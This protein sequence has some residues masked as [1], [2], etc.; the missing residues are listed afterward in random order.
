[1]CVS[2]KLPFGKPGCFGC[3]ACAI[4][5]RV[6]FC[7]DGLC[8]DVMFNMMAHGILHILTLKFERE[9]KD[10]P[11]THYVPKISIN[12]LPI[13]PHTHSTTNSHDIKLMEFLTVKKRRDGRASF[14]C[15]CNTGAVGADLCR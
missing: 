7:C 5:L 8:H 3:K 2:V 6:M 12:L 9:T 13:P 4:L 15:A 10:T 1:M 11:S 14:S